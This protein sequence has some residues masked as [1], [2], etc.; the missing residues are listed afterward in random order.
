MSKFLKECK[1]KDPAP[2]RQLGLPA[3]AVEAIARSLGASSEPKAYTTGALV[4]VAFFFLLRVGEYTPSP[5]SRN[6]ERYL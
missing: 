5:Q 3:S 1:E 4:V 2:E 6:S